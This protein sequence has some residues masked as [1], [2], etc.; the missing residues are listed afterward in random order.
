MILLGD[1]NVEFEEAQMAEL[2]NMESLKNL[3]K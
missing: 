1:F 3:T 2:L